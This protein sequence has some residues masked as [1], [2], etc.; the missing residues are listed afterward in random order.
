MQRDDS[1]PWPPAELARR[2]AGARRLAWLIGGAALLL[3]VAGLF[4][5]R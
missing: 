3:Y 5:R 2:R 1:S 4:I